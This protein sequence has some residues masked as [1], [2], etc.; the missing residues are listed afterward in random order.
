ME[1]DSIER[2]ADNDA[3]AY[4]ATAD[5]ST[6]KATADSLALI[7]SASDLAV[8][9]AKRTDAEK[10]LLSKGELLLD[11]V[12]FETGKTIIS[13]NSKPYLNIIGKMLIK[14][15]K[16]MIEVAGYTDNVG[17]KAYNVTL[18][19]GRA[20]SVLAYLDEVSPVLSSVLSAHGYGMDMPK[21][22]NGTKEG[23]L[24]N[25]RVELRVTNKDALQLYSQ[26]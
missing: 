10:Q 14:Y 26:N 5:A 17:G 7:Q 22:D 16:L 11:N 9:K 20:E 24:I 3:Q 19:Q 2:Q 12:Y 1:R 23:R 15:P 13:I 21:A 6:K 25:R 8:E 18:S 4:Q